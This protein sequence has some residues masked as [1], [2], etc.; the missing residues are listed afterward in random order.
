[1]KSIA[2][3][4]GDKRELFEFYEEYLKYFYEEPTKEHLLLI[5]CLKVIKNN[6]VFF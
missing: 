5:N 4:L 3:L 2:D 6:K 1:M